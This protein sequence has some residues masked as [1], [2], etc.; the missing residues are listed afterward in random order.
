MRFMGIMKDIIT[1]NFSNAGARLF[2]ILTVAIGIF[3]LLKKRKAV[4]KLRKKDDSFLLQV[5]SEKYLFGNK[6][7][8]V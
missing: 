3:G 6:R 8:N 2:A 5:F 7:I 4:Q 1:F